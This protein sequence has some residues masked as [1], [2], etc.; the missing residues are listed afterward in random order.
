MLKYIERY[1]KKKKSTVTK[2]GIKDIRG[3][4]KVHKLTF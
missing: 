4:K 1:I 3:G 2:F